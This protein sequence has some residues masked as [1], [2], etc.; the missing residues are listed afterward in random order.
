MILSADTANSVADAEPVNEGATSTGKLGVGASIALNITPDTTS[1]TI[2]DTSTL[3]DASDVT[4]SAI[5]TYTET[6]TAVNGA[7]A[8]DGT[9]IGIS[10]AIA[11]VNNSATATVG[12]LSNPLV[13]SGAFSSTATQTDTVTTSSDG[14]AAGTNAVGIAIG[15]GV[16]TDSATAMTSQSITA[17]GAVSFMASSEATTSALA[18]ASAAGGSPMDNSSGKNVDGQVSDQ[19]SFGD[20]QA[21]NSGSQG[22]PSGHEG[23]AAQNSSGTSVSLAGGIGVNIA[24]NESSATL[25]PNLVVNA[26]GLLTL[27]SANTTGANATADGSAT[28]TSKVGVGVAIA[29]NLVKATND[30]EIAAG[31]NVTAAG[32]TISALMAGDGT[33]MDSFG[34][35]ATSGASAGNVAVAGSLA[36]NIVQ[37]NSATASIDSTSTVN[38]GGMPVMILSADTANS[39]ADAEP[40]NEGATSTGKLGVGASIALNITPDTT[41]ATIGDTSTC[42]MRRT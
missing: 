12:A 1:S 2:G 19:M 24:T 37:A 28:G 41:S 33:P 23:A 9:G 18:S 17:G 16:S 26:G 6:T 3:S 4:L 14:K 13:I 42:P 36:I 39:V 40:V 31:D 7:M 20:N 10:A 34:A 25:A 22:A 21:M 11:I 8:T 5:G 30:A 27:S 32:V 29:L 38:A 35:K 15:V